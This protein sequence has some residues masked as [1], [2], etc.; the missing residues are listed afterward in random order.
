MKLDALQTQG[1]PYIVIIQKQ[2]KRL[3]HLHGTD[4][5]ENEFEDLLTMTLKNEKK[6]GVWRKMLCRNPREEGGDYGRSRLLIY[7][8]HELG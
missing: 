6:L 5:V 8:T 2:L 1:F 3:Q 4:R 7:L